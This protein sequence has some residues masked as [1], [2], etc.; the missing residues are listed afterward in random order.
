MA[1]IL[2]IVQGDAQITLGDEVISAC[3]NTWVHMEARLPHSIRA[4][5]PLVMLLIL[6]R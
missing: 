2:H 6:M 1:A 5:T 3:A 4:V